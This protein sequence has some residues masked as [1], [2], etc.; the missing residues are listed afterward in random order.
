[1]KLPILAVHD[2]KTGLFDNM[3]TVRHTADAIRD[4]DVVSKDPNHKYGKNPSDFDLML[5]G[6]YDDELGQ[7]ENQKPHTHLASGV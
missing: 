5:I 7:V 6:H 4:W 2:K 3:F 1:M